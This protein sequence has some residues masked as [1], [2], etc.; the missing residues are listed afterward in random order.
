MDRTTV[1]NKH[2][3]RPPATAVWIT[4]PGPWGSPFELGLHG[5]RDEVLFRYKKWLEEQ[6]PE[7]FA[8]VKRMLKGQVLVCCC[9][10]KPCHGDFLVAIAEDEPWPNHGVH[11]GHLFEGL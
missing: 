8:R 4:R 9:A 11:Q 2:T 3:R 6:P 7:F 1:I 5:N 10:P